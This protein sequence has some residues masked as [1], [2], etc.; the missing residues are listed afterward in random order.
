MSQN[1]HGSLR[2]RAGL[3][4]PRYAI[5]HT[6]DG[7]TVLKT[8][9]LPDSFWKFVRQLPR[10][11]ADWA[12][13]RHEIVI[14]FEIPPRERQEPE[15]LNDGGGLIS[16]WLPAFGEVLDALAADGISE[17]TIAQFMAKGRELFP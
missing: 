16:E 9:L 15:W 3:E 17:P 2:E 8:S 6:L 13:G 12:P 10:Q 4:A 11:M 7:E 1:K 14:E 5:S